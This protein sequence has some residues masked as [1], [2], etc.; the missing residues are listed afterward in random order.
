MD[1]PKE[2]TIN[3]VRLQ[4][5]PTGEFNFSGEITEENR[6]VVEATLN[7]AAFYKIKSVQQEESKNLNDFIVSFAVF[8]AFLTLSAT[9]LL[10][11]GTNNKEI[12]GKQACL[13]NAVTLYNT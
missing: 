13:G 5:T 3:K 9:L 6:E 11:I 1:H 7:Q 12:K 10:G 8:L 2:E 4:I